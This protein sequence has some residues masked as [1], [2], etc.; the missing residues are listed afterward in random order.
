MFNQLLKLIKVLNSEASP[1][2]IASGI[3]L[4]MYLGF[5]PLL[6]L[7]SVFIIL[8]VCV[9]RVNLSAFILATAVFSVLALALDPLFIAVGEALLTSAGLNGF[10][11]ALYQSDLMR[12]MQFNHTLIL[13]T[14]C[15]S[16]LALVPVWLL[17]RFLIVG[18]RVQFMAMVEKWKV[19]KLIKASD[20]FQRYL[21]LK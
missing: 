13:G 2:Q 14:F 9:T 5:G 20:M 3:A 19:T 6:A 11:T 12:L 8:I 18:Y 16:T 4:A 17:S 10:W 15:V 21:E 1:H 7:Q